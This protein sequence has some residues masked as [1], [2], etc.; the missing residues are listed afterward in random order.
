[1]AL[2]IARTQRQLLSKGVRPLDVIALGIAGLSR[3]ARREEHQTLR[4][5]TRAVVAIGHEISRT[6][7]DL[8]AVIDAPRSNVVSRCNIQKGIVSQVA[9]VSLQALGK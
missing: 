9:S 1:M 6:D 8:R 7:R 3:R 2:A 4:S 5:D